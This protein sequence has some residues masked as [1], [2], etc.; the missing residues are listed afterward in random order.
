M[1]DDILPYLNRVSLD[2]FSYS[3]KFVFDPQFVGFPVSTQPPWLIGGD[4]F[5][6]FDV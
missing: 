1:L 5:V 3:G 2:G 6:S 4:G